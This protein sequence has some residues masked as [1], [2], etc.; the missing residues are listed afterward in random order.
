M[1]CIRIEQGC[2]YFLIK[3]FVTLNVCVLVNK[4]FQQC[5][6]QSTKIILYY[7]WWW[8]SSSLNIAIKKRCLLMIFVFFFWNRFR[9]S[10]ILFCFSFFQIVWNKKKEK[11]N[12]VEKNKTFDR[13]DLII[14]DNW[15][16]E[17]C[18]NFF[19]P[20]QVIYYVMAV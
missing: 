15:H 11:E 19:F 20:T 6:D 2:V 13:L 17:N 7:C 8:A 18:H 10:Y 5:P 12:K 3:Y 4:K 9:F 16:N 1:N 14:I